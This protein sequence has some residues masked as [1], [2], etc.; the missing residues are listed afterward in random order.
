M[1]L[2]DL[3]PVRTALRTRFGILPLQPEQE[4]LL[5]QIDRVGREA[6]TMIE[7][8]RSSTIRAVIEATD[9]AGDFSR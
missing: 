9:Q 4:D 7:Q 2:P 5:R 8:V 3:D 1:A 6:D